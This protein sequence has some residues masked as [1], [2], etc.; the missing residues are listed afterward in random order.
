MW[1]LLPRETITMGL[2]DEFIPLKHRWAGQGLQASLWTDTLHRTAPELT[3]MAQKEWSGQLGT[4]PEVWDTP[5]DS[6]GQLHLSYVHLSSSSKFQS[7]WRISIEA[8]W[9]LVK[10]PCPTW[11]FL[12][13]ELL[14]QPWPMRVIWLWMWQRHISLNC[15]LTL[16]S[17]SS[18]PFAKASA[19]G[20]LP[21]EALVLNEDMELS[22][23]KGQPNPC[24]EAT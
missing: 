24:P 9:K 10:D 1:S 11:S 3:T 8:A 5:A 2:I 13:V 19:M 18:Q 21:S 16:L 6:R 12:W 15:S 20:I 17:S 7:V 23:A 4:V 22:P 14:L